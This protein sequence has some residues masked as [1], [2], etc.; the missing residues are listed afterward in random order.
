MHK[1]I[2]LFI[3]RL[4]LLFGSLVL[5][6]SASA[7]RDVP[8]GRDHPEL[9]RIPG[10]VLTGFEHKQYGTLRLPLKIEGIRVSRSLQPSG[11][12]WRLQYRLPKKMGPDGA[13][14]VYLD[15][16]KE[17]GFE[18]L[19]QCEDEDTMFYTT[20]RRRLKYQWGSNIMTVYCLVAK[21]TL[22]GREATVGVFST[23]KL[24]GSEPEVRL[25]IVESKPLEAKL[26]VVGAEKMAQEIEKKG[27]VALYGI[28]FDHDSDKL[29]PDSLKAIAEIAKYLSAH[30][31]VKLYVVG[32]T[33]NTGTYQ[34]NLDLSKRRAR[35]VVRSL[36]RKHGIS[37]NRLKAVGVGP[38]APVASNQTEEGRAKNRRVELVAQ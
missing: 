28:L 12:V 11:E 23:A 4:V 17:K 26:E 5:A 36:V 1:S 8:G 10:S 22:R 19:Y 25:Y 35:A 29:K 37:A 31:K 7:G 18:L 27:H 34:Y 16:L 21:G 9:G 32:H 30:P 6:S 15:N 2:S 3:V 38:V 24:R 20:L 33:D 14:A 13:Y